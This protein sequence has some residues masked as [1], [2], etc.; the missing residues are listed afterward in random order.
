MAFKSQCDALKFMFNNKKKLTIF[1]QSLFLL[2]Y[3]LSHSI[4][5]TIVSYE[6]CFLFSCFKFLDIDIP[7]NQ[8]KKK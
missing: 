1:V 6:Y 2:H 7:H 3:R 5:S 4:V 8:T